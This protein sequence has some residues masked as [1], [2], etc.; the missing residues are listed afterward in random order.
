MLDLPTSLPTKFSW[1][2][3]ATYLVQVLAS[4]LSHEH[5]KVLL[6]G[7]DADA[8]GLTNGPA[9][10]RG[11]QGADVLG[12]GTG[13]DWLQG[14]AGADYLS[15]ADLADPFG[16]LDTGADRLE[17]DRG[18]DRLMGGG[19]DD[20]LIGGRDDDLLAGNE[21]ADVF[22]F[23]RRGFGQDRIVDFTPGED[24]IDLSG[25]GL[26]F[27]QIDTN[28]NGMIEAD[29]HGVSQEGPDL[30]MTLGGGII[31]LAGVT[32]LTANDVLI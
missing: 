28:G 9:L 20:T 13:V 32:A 6:G 21:G 18:N 16:E 3:G 25:L 5:D 10:V 2:D 31:E 15:G 14:G 26:A 19:G 8:L 30:V 1:A 27:E 22:V 17:G 23:D 24:R 29:D 12:G 4:L 11:G 7:R